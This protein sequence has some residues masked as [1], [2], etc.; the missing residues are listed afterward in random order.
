M[1]LSSVE[2][3]FEDQTQPLLFFENCQAWK[4]FSLQLFIS[5]VCGT[6]SEHNK[7]PIKIKK[8]HI[9]LLLTTVLILNMFGTSDT[10]KTSIYYSNLMNRSVNTMKFYS[11]EGVT[12][13]RRRDFLTG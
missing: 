13:M 2:R 10:N 11:V 6:G 4:N 7:C 1:Q 8:N 9:V 12:V 5:S 3:P